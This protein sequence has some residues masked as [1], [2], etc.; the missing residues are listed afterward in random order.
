MKR[1]YRL[2]ALVLCLLLTACAGMPSEEAKR[3]A[4]VAPAKTAVTA[5]REPAVAPEIPL[6]AIDPWQALRDSFAMGG[7]NSD[8][9]VLAQA[10]RDTRNPAQFES[11]LRDVLPRLIYVQ[12]VA[13][14]HAVAGEFVLL[15][16][17]ESRFRPLP[18]R[19]NR[20][21]GMW[22]IMPVTAGSM[23]LRV[24][25]HYDGRMDVPAAAEAVMT[26]LAKYQDQFRDWRVTD[27]AYNAGEYAI[28]RIIRRHGMP[29][30]EPVI[31][32]WPVPR[33]TREHLIKLLGM[34]C[35]VREPDRFHVTLPTLPSGQQLVKVELPRSMPMVQA[36]E[37]AAMPVGTLRDLNSAFLG[38]APDVRA[39]AYLLLPAAH[40]VQLRNALLNQPKNAFAGD[41]PQ[42]APASDLADVPAPSFTPAK[43][44]TVRRGESLWQIA[45]NYS[46]DMTQ[47][48]RWNHLHGHALKPG[49]VLKV[50]A[51]GELD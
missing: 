5:A 9:A 27:Y 45:R 25:R 18:G 7:C 23:S 26:L 2:P 31:P 13:A 19:R 51:A 38:N 34:A 8:P 1:Q 36:A 32:H 24:D 22:Q 39:A 4:L 48:K 41:D 40:A 10:R 14:R 21:A 28:R 6:Q 35:V 44:H 42:G 11:Q 16:W 33:V 20:P 15:P 37:Q 46:V 3:P 47:L 43:T 12:Q 17:I 49:Q 29:P 50:S 30:D